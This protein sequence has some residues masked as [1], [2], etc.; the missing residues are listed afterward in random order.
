MCKD[1][2]WATFIRV[3][4]LGTWVQGPHTRHSSQSSHSNSSVTPTTYRA[5]GRPAPGCFAH[6][7]D[8]HCPPFS[9]HGIPNNFLFKV[10]A[11]QQARALRSEWPFIIILL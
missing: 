4:A 9:P 11:H 8:L 6:L 2:H 3:C 5:P 1:G 10:V 7:T